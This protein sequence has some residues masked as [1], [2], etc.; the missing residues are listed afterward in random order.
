M[1]LPARC[2]HPRA[3]V[4]DRPTGLGLRRRSSEAK[5]QIPGGSFKQSRRSKPRTQRVM[6]AHRREPGSPVAPAERKTP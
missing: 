3:G 1:W 5:F 4:R 2:L 6:E